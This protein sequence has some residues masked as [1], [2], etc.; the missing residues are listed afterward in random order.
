M[1]APS[2]IPIYYLVS[3]T[4]LTTANR[5]QVIGG[6]SSGEVEAVLLGTP[7]GMLVGVGSDHTDR[8][9]ETDSIVISKQVCPKSIARDLWR[10]A[11]VVASWDNIE[12]VSDRI[13]DGVRTTYQRG[14]MAAVRKP[15]DLIGD[16]F[17]GLEELPAG[18][19]MYTGTIPT[20]GDITGADYFTMALVDPGNGRALWPGYDAWVLSLVR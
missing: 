18:V 15:E 13:V 3:A 19:A 5:L 2:S 6:D 8:K 9:M 16:Y 7:K 10:Y 17:D 12:L 11:D 14:K 4:L 1:P 20:I